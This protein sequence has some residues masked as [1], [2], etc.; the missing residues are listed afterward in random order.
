MINRVFLSCFSVFLLCC[1]SVSAFGS[2]YGHEESDIIS[3]T[4]FKVKN[5]GSVIGAELNDLVKQSYGKTLYFQA[6]TYNLSEPIVLPFDYTKNVNIV[7]DKN[8]RIKTDLPLEALLKI[9][10]SEMSTPD[11]THRRFSYIEG[12]MFD[13]SNVD[14]GIMVN[15]LKQLV[16]LRAISLFKGRKIHIRIQVT[17]D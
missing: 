2:E 9:G 4:K 12:G 6:G 5:D 10:Y 3:V 15:G 7:F 8:A 17:D 16:S 14:N 1:F 11:V 13:C